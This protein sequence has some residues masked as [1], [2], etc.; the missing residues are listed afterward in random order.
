MNKNNALNWAEQPNTTPVLGANAQ[1]CLWRGLY[2]ETRI[3]YATTPAEVRALH[4]LGL[5]IAAPDM[6]GNTPLHHAVNGQVTVAMLKLYP[7][8]KARYAAANALN[9]FNRTPLHHAEDADQT[10][11]LLVVGADPNKVDGDGFAPLH[12]A[13]T[14]EQ[15]ALLIDAGA[16]VCACA[17]GYTPLML[18]LKFR[19]ERLDL[20]A[21]LAVQDYT[22]LP[23]SV[24]QQQEA[25]LNAAQM[26]NPTLGMAIYAVQQ[27]EA[28]HI[29]RHEK[30]KACYDMA[31]QRTA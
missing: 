30:T 8:A 22:R 1:A 13:R 21:L 5:D 10:K 20:I 9:K 25:L 3:H 6:Y 31:N 28:H 17:K 7:N 11:A 23:K 12:F 27:E 4:Q 29:T 16:N 18:Q 2:N 26:K 15:A 24:R 19:P 14:A